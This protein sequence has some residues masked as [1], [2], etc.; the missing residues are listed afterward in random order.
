MTH[1]DRS[2]HDLNVPIQHS[3]RWFQDNLGRTLLLRGINVCGSSKLPTRPYPGSTHLY[4]DILFWDHRNVSFVNRPFPLEDAHEHFSRLSAWGLTLIRLLVPWES[5]EHEGPGCYD[6]EYIDYLR[7]LIEMMPRYGIKCIID[8]HQDTWSRFSGGSG[9]PGWTFEVAGLNIKHFKETGA[10]YVHNTN[11]VPGDPLPM[12]WPTNY[13]KLASCT[14]FTLFFAGDTFAP[15][16]TYQ[17]QSIQQFLNHHFIEAYRH[18]AE[19]LSDLQAVLAFEFMNEPHPGYIGL[20]HLDSFDPIMNLLFGDSPTPLQSF[21]LGDGIPQTVGVYVKS[22]PFPTKKSHDR[23]I[24]ASQTSAWFSGCVWKEHGVWTVDDQG[25]PRLVNTHYFSKHPKTG[26]KVSFYED[27]YKPLVNRYVAAI[28]SVK[29]EYYCL[30]EP[31]ANEKPPVYNEHDHHHNVIF[32]PHW[33]D[34]DS[35]FYKKFNA[36]MTHDVQCLQRGGNVFSATYF[37]KRGAK[38]NYRGQI[39]NIKEDG[40]L[41][42]GEKPCVMGE[43]GIPMDLNNKMA[44]EDDNYENHVHFMDAIIYA[45][46]TN[47][48]SFTLWN[49]DVFNDHEYGDHWNGEN[50][51]IY[52]VKKSEEDY[53]RHDD[54]NSKLSKKHLYDGGRVLEAVLRPYAAKVAGTPVSAEFNIDTLQYTFSFI[55][56]CKG[57]TTTE[58]FVPYFHYGNKTIKTDISFGRC[59][60]IEE[61]QTL[62]HQYELN[63]PLPKLVT[64]TM[65]VLTAESANSCNVIEKGPYISPSTGARKLGGLSST[66]R[67]PN[68]SNVFSHVRPPTTPLPFQHRLR[69]MKLSDEEEE[70]EQDESVYGIS[71]S[72]K[73]YDLMTEF[74]NLKNPNHCPLGVYVMP[75]SENLYVWY[76]VIFVH[77]GYYSSGTFKF[78]LAI[79]ESYPEYPPAVTFMSDMFHPLV[80]GG[81]N[82]SITQQFPTW[83][84]Y[85]DYIFHILHYIKNIFKKNI[86][87]RLIDKHCFNKE[88]YRLYRTDIKVF[89]KLAQQCSQLSITESYLFDHFPDDNMI[90]FSPMNESTFDEIWSHIVKQ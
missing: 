71:E 83:R 89:S 58:I 2:A 42:M 17:A 22:W 63:E 43:V 85:E 18:L 76:G 61:F 19:R 40:L 34:L 21:A 41:N 86:L 72:F 49:Y 47:L 77:Q 27:F 68:V 46:E 88:A 35:V 48:I 87:D 44:F 75:S 1:P 64:I 13:T 79:P 14:M 24:N 74:I 53:M 54:G 82:L 5:I 25:V 26:E 62:Y 39:K 65:G 28:Q 56:D 11:A 90:R 12:V 45:L 4:D 30:V 57:S 37:G 8:P 78:R 51:S 50:F 73:R 52:S 70:E 55:P 38:K 84:P 81:G 80:D 29:K 7:Q 10:A 60:Y 16:R 36:R 20:D 15:H 33:Y 59:S 3:G 32:S 6:E 67:S 69:R 9:A 66:T 23:V 31:L